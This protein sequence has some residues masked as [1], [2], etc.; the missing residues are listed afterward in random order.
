MSKLV[1]EYSHRIF[2]YIRIFECYTNLY[3]IDITM[4]YLVVHVL[5]YMHGIISGLYQWRHVRKSTNFAQT[6]RQSGDV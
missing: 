5:M 1:F 2:E 4:T 6:T 3:P